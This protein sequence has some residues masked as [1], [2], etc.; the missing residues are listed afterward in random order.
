MNLESYCWSW[1]IRDPIVRRKPTGRVLLF[2]PVTLQPVN[3]PRAMPCQRGPVTPV[4]T[5]EDGSLL[6]APNVGMLIISNGSVTLEDVPR[7]GLVCAVS[8]YRGHGALVLFDSGDLIEL[9]G[10]WRT[11]AKAGAPVPEYRKPIAVALDG[12]VTNISMRPFSHSVAYVHNQ[13]ERSDGVHDVTL[14]NLTRVRQSGTENWWGLL[15]SYSRDLVEQ[16]SCKVPGT[17]AVF[18]M[19]LVGAGPEFVVV[20]TAGVL[21]K[22][23]WPGPTL[24]LAFVRAVLLNAIK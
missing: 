24:R 17:G 15:R 10:G 4:F 19:Q 9:A 6:C 21:S 13:L 18:D 2:D 1:D 14:L 20:C 23:Q 7:S 16:W 12:S 22:V 11:V 5:L 8:R 3:P